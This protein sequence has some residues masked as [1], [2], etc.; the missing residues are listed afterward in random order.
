MARKIVPEAISSD[1]VLLHVFWT[2]T[3]TKKMELSK[4]QSNHHLIIIATCEYGKSI[5][6]WIAIIFP[7]TVL[8]T[9]E[10]I[11]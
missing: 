8:R 5:S 11:L 10:E 2:F 7:N 1:R 6:W 9:K 4:N 3:Y